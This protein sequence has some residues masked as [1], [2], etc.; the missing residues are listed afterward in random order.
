M[1]TLTLF[2]SHLLRRLSPSKFPSIPRNPSIASTPS[3]QVSFFFPSISLCAFDSC[4]LIQ[5]RLCFRVLI[6][7]ERACHRWQLRR[8]P[9]SRRPTILAFRRIWMMPPK[10]ISCSKLWAFGFPFDF[11]V[12]CLS[13]CVNCEWFL[14]CRCSGLRIR[15][16]AWISTLVCLACR[17]CS[18]C[19]CLISWKWIIGMTILDFRL[20]FKL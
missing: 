3:S 8:S 4:E 11:A 12:K 16:L 6:G 10:A 20:L 17:E 15:K 13:F 9:R 1:A 2:S 19:V 14:V 7:S 18:L 5:S